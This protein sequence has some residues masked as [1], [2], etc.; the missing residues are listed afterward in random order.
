MQKE[1]NDSRYNKQYDGRKNTHELLK[2]WKQG[3]KPLNKQHKSP[4][5]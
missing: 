4:E 5:E 2:G 3:N 1:L